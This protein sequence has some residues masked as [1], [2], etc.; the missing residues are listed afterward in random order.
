[1]NHKNVMTQYERW[2]R[3]SLKIIKFL[4]PFELKLLLN[5]SF[6][7]NPMTYIPYVNQK[8][9]RKTAKIKIKIQFFF[10]VS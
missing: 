9:L 2:K 8:N 7:L 5:L 10:K 6:M 1:M 3:A 4:W